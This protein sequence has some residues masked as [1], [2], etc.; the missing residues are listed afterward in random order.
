M[1]DLKV[2]VDVKNMDIFQKVIQILKNVSED[3][4]VSP[5]VREEIKIKTLELLKED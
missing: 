4:R 5:E 3:E 2:K 1:A